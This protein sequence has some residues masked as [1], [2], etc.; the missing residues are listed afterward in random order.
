M[1]VF[2]ARAEYL[3]V[4]LFWNNLY[5]IYKAAAAVPLGSRYIKSNLSIAASNESEFT[6]EI[7]KRIRNL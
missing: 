2:G 7:G 5:C 4:G 6:R 1:Q 3:S